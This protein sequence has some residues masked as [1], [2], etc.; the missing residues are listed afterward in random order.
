MYYYYDSEGNLR[1][2]CSACIKELSLI[3]YEV[4]QCRNCRKIYEEE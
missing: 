3:D 2:F 1:A 4:Y